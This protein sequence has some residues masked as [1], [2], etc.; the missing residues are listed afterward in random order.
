MKQDEM[1]GNRS[2]AEEVTDILR[3]RI[4]HGEYAMGEKLTENKIAA[5][6][7]VSR[8]PIRDAFRQLEQ[9]QLVEY[10]PN[11]G[12]FARGFSKEDM[13]D[14]Y[15]VREAVEELAIRRVVRCAGDDAIRQ[16]ESQLEKMRVYTEQNIYEKL[17]QANEEFHIMIYR[18]TESRFI[19]QTMK[20]YQDYVHLARKETL[21]K[22]EYLSEIYREHEA[23]YD[24]IAARDE[25]A[26]VEAA[27]MHLKHS[28]ERAMERW[29]GRG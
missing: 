26:A 2:L 11:K 16:L 21:K 3:T 1:S 19:V 17:L 28:C 7:K 12:C 20:T 13:K 9:D 23:I 29:I 18:M 6:L 15:A 14:I 5:E 8:T 4:L 22:E 27:R 24:A 25:A 10:I